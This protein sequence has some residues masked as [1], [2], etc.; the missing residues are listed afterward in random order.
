M[1]IDAEKSALGPEREGIPITVS[2]DGTVIRSPRIDTTTAQATVSAASGETIILGGLITNN[3]QSIDRRVPYLADIPLLGQL[4]RFDSLTEQRTELLIILTPHVIRSPADS[5]RLK[6]TEMA[7]MSWC[8]A[9]IYRV[10]GD[11]NVAVAPDTQL[12]QPTQ[13]IYPDADPRGEQPMPPTPELRPAEP[14]DLPSLRGDANANADADA[15][16]IEE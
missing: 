4:F 12:N 3:K 13:V 11:L 10:H 16:A 9:D 8:A 15:D 7:R 14:P 2:I 6:Q 1:E 5:E